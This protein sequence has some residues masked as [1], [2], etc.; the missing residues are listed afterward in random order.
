MKFK[1]ILF[2]V[3]F[4]DCSRALNGEVEYLAKRFNSDVALMHVFEIPCSWYGSGDVPLMNSECLQEYVTSVRDRL[5]DYS[6]DIPKDRVRRIIA[7]GDAAWQIKT[8]VAENN[9]DL[10]VMGTHGYGSVR[11]LL[12]GSVAM[13]VLHD[14]HCPVWTH[15]MAKAFDRRV[16]TDVRT[17]VCAL[18]LDLEAAPL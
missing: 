14:V 4:S 18:E 8:A 2:P 5:N 12:L 11:R 1:N 6:I 10:V 16:L 17:I 15:A 3:D 7:E 9:F 13:K